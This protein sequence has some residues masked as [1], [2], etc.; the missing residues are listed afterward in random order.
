MRLTK[1]EHSCVLVEES[2]ARILIDPGSFSTGFEELTDLEAVLITHQHADHV[3]IDRLGPL[4]ERNR[5]CALFADEGTTAVLS[6]RGISA[7]IARAGE[8][9][10][11]DVDVVVHGV[12]HAVIHPD[13][14]MIPNVGYLIAGRFF[15]PGD[16]FT[17][18][19]PPVDVLALPTGAPWLKVADA[20]DYLRQVAPRI[21]I[22]I[23]EAVLARPALHYGLFERLALSG[24][25]MQVVEPGT[26]VSL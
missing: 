1:Y 15:H 26:T 6:D 7:T 20:V 8:R 24:T 9:L 19:D 5:Q 22:P 23:H 14:P 11:L 12:N 21:A 18:P 3:D 16:S 17:V 10:P 25:T 4:L 2:G 13:I